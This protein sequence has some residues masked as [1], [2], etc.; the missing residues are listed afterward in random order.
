MNPPET[1]TPGR[2]SEI[3]R[4]VDK[5]RTFAIISH[6]DAGKTTLTEKLL[7]YSGLVRT[8]GIVGGRKHRKAAMSDWME[9]EKE[10]GISVTA[11]AMQFEY[12]D[13]LINV[14]DT[15]GHQDFSED[16]YRTLTAADS[17]VMVIDAAKGV[18]L[19]TRK[20]F[21]VCHIRGNPVLT[22]INKMDLPGQ[23]PL[24][25][26]AEVEEALGIQGYAWNWPVGSGPDFKGIVDRVS[27]DLILFEK[28]QGG[29]TIAD[30][31]TLPWASD[32][33]REL[34]GSDLYEAVQEELELVEVA[35]NDFDR[36][37]F[38]DGKLTPFFFGS[39]LTNFGVGPFFDA[40]VD[41]APSPYARPATG[42]EG[43]I[44][45]D[46]VDHDF[47]AFVFK[48]Q[49]NMNP[50]HRDSTAF[51]RVVS[52]CLDRARSV[53]HHRLGRAV[54]LSRPHSLM[55]G[56][57]STIDVAYPGDVVGVIN[58]GLFHI[59]DTVSLGGGFEFPPLPHFQP[60]VFARIRPTDVSKRKSFDKGLKQLAEEGM[61]Q[62]LEHIDRKETICAVCGELQFEVLCHRLEKE[63]SV[64][65]EL[66]RLGFQCSAWLEGDPKTFRVPYKSIMAKDTRG[67]V[68]VLFESPWG[69]RTAQED[70]PDHVLHEWM[71]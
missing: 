69:K 66:S 18:E 47:S 42:E 21:E 13:H 59:G 11:S 39:A 29:A 25:L 62:V 43:P 55:A 23:E 53:T 16:T 58:P 4:E 8:A 54:R 22:F 34:C 1:E 45:I 10:R 60:E 19:Q 33:A 32:E 51:L 35:G 57:R 63:Y 15:P 44:R 46:P 12:G 67:R 64:E 28:S 27:G 17:A 3:R 2:R 49:A 20:L 7:L 31:K 14:L 65:T 41:L 40:F 5:R 48:I 30:S 9:L 61:V 38:L 24:D 36:Q 68:M 26:M 56:G 52:G 71:A 6:P 37:A 50:R 70:N